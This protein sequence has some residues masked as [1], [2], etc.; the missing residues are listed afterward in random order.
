MSTLIVFGGGWKRGRC[1]EDICLEAN[2]LHSLV[3]GLP[4]L[5]R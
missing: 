1:L 4:K 5:S 2:A 3:G